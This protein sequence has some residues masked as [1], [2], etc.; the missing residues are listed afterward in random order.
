MDTYTGKQ[1]LVLGAGVSGRGVASVLADCGAKVVLSDSNLIDEDVPAVVLLAKKGVRI[2]SGRQDESLLDGVDRVIVSPGIP[3][4]IPILEIARNKHISIVSEVEVAYDLAKAPILGVTGTNGKTTTTMLLGE[5]LRHSGKNVFVGGNIGE[6]LSLET[7]HATAKDYIVA[8][9]S[10]YQ[11][12]GIDTFKT[13]GSIILNVT[14]D[15]LQRHKTMEAYQKAKENI[16]KNQDANGYT[17]LNEDDS[18]VQSMSSRVHG[19]LLYISQQ[20]PV[21]NG[22]YFADNVLYAVADGVAVEVIRTDAI[23]LRGAHNVE[24]VLAVI[25]LT[26]ALDVTPTC[27][28]EAIAA[29]G[30]VEH[31]IEPVRT[32]DGATYYNDSKATNT[33]SVMKALASFKEP[34]VLIAGGFDKMEDLTNFMK[35]VKSRVK[36]VIFMGAAAERFAEAARLAGI[37]QLVM[38]SDMK[39]AVAKGRTAAS[40][41][42]V[43]LL[44]PA[45]SSFDYYSCFEERGEDFKR[46]VMSLDEGEGT[47]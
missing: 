36:T 45:C 28:A 12:E 18:I 3:L 38:A 30:A 1:I 41:G 47:H 31:R 22:A 25:A 37:T 23:Q 40:P 46:I 39:D 9:L 8:E 26:Y 5:V 10:S 7:V 2:I 4:T 43:V 42:D 15:H 20:H 35:D 24:N 19:K 11:L 21:T 14:P 13:L 27:M 32:V 34:I 17:V 29:F 33:D 44:S 6:A 16:F